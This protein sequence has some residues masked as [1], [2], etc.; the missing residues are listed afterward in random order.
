MKKQFLACILMLAC[1]AFSDATLA[2]MRVYVREQPATPVIVRPAAPAPDHL[3]V[4]HEWVV[5]NG[6]YVHVPG[7]WAVP[8]RGRVK[9][10]PGRWKNASGHGYY[11]VPGHWV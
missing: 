11:W 3:W 2:Q 4:E 7:Y 1:F 6:V 5:R 9:W 10:V 8:P